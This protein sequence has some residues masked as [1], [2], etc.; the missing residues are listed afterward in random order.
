MA[1][2]INGRQYHAGPRGRIRL[3]REEPE[4]VISARAFREISAGKGST[5]CVGNLINEN[6]ETAENVRFEF[7]VFTSALVKLHETSRRGLRFFGDFA[8]WPVR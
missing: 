2:L 8:T 6:R 5:A 4:N 1:N 7:A 3:T